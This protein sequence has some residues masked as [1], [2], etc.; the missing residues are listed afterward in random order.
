MQL[1]LLLLFNCIIYVL[2]PLSLSF[3]ENQCQGHGYKA[4]AAHG[5]V[6]YL[7]SLGRKPNEKIFKILTYQYSQKL[8]KRFNDFCYLL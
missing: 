2:T 6:K 3:I 1:L 5:Y 8:N 7:R 4:I